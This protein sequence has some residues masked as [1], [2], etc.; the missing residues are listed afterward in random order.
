MKKYRVQF[1]CVDTW[2]WKTLNE[3]NTLKEA[4]ELFRAWKKKLILNSFRIQK[5]TKVKKAKIHIIDKTLI[6]P[7][8]NITN[9]K[10]QK[11]LL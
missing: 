9:Y 5:L 1:Y 4:E 7:I 8:K 2:R 11:K 6:N 10:W 3:C